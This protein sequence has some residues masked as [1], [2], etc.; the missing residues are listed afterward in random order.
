MG[1][2][3]NAG[4][5]RDVINKDRLC[6]RIIPFSGFKRKG[7]SI[8][9]RIDPLFTAIKLMISFLIAIH[10]GIQYNLYNV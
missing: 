6:C 10:K 4:L 2:T 7:I 3:N 5:K 8:G 1:I 9:I